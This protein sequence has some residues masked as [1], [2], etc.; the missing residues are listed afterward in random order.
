MNIMKQLILNIPENKLGFF[1][2]LIENLDFVKVAEERE[3]QLT[4]EQADFI[5]GLKDSFSQVEGH[6]H[7]RIKLQSAK[8]LLN[9]L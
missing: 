4:P 2:E 3:L 8:D 6:V 7:G 9:E 5:D 1:K